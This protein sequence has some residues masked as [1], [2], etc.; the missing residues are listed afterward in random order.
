VTA[1]MAN[2]LAFVIS[3]KFISFVLMKC[4]RTTNSHQ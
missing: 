1:V 3:H 4:I 2:L